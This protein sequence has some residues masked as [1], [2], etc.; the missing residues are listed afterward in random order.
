V[1]MPKPDERSAMLM[2]VLEEIPAGT[3]TAAFAKPDSDAVFRVT[4]QSKIVRSFLKNRL[5]K[6]LR[7]DPAGGEGLIPTPLGPLRASDFTNGT[8]RYQ[9]RL[10]SRFTIKMGFLAS[11]G[12]NNPDVAFE[13]A[14]PRIQKDY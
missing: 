3:L 2:E 10:S 11:A 9:V 6:H 7:T 14:Y 4:P 13:I 12:R 8:L 5:Q 1:G